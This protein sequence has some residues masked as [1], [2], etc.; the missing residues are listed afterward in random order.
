MLETACAGIG[1]QLHVCHRRNNRIFHAIRNSDGSW[2][3]VG[4][5]DIS[6][7]QNVSSNNFAVA[8]AG[9]GNELH[10]CLLKNDGRIFHAIRNPDGS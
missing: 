3:G 4:F 7:I 1:T 2:V 5:N 8:S 6:G 10:V 9:V